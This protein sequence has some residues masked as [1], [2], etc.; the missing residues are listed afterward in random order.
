LGRLRSTSRLRGSARKWGFSRGE[1]TCD[2]SRRHGRPCS[3]L[4]SGLAQQVELASVEGEAQDL[5]D[6]S[7]ARLAFRVSD[8][9]EL[10][11]AVRKLLHDALAESDDEQCAHRSQ[12]SLYAATRV[13]L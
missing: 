13:R 4:H 7:T 5:F 1:T 8:A 3:E 6:L 11:V 12:H 9:L 10:Y 2:D